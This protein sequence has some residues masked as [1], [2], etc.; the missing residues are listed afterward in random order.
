MSFQELKERALAEWDAFSACGRPRVL[1]GAGTCGRAAGAEDIIQAV[2]SHLAGRGLNADVRQV[3]CLGLCYAEPLVELSGPAMPR[4]LYGGLEPDRVPALLDDFFGRGELREDC[5]LAVMDGAAAGGIPAFHELPMLRGQVRI[6]LR[7]CGL[8]DPDSILHYVARGGYAG[9]ARALQMAPEQ[10]IEEV[11][12]SGLRGRGGVGFPTGRKWES[13]RLAA[14]EPKYVVANAEEGEAG[15]FKDR[16]LIEGDPHL[17]LEGMLIAGY[18]VGASRGIIFVQA[19]YGLCA[20]RLRRAIDAAEKQGL[21]GRRILGSGFSF[22]LSVYN[23][24]GGYV[25]GE[26][27]ALLECLE[28]RRAIP[29]AKPPFPA[30]EGLEGQPTVINN[31]ETLAGVP[32]IL[33]HGAPSYRARGTEGS[34]GTK[35]FSLSG[36]LKRPGTVEFP[37]GVTLRQLIFEASGGMPEGRRFRAVLVGGPTG[38]YVPESYLDLPLDFDSLAPI[39]AMM[40]SGAI[41]VTDD[42]TCILDSVIHAARFL[43]DESCGKCAPCRLGTQQMVR[44][45]HRI[46]TGSGRPG[47]PDL[48]TELAATLKRSALCGLGQAAGNPVVGSLRHFRAEYQSHIEQALCPAGVCRLRAA[49]ST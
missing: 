8:V 49:R 5:A 39:D 2:N 45:L 41:V 46:T 42:R 18:A 6:V 28:G 32:A 30:Q 48:L 33:L 9:L 7:N 15:T 16:M 44:I 3:G 13:V 21:C 25:C 38:G 35:L 1:V 14:G 12:R 22:A 43:A 47:D 4:V 23:A 11:N 31:V 27:T 36:D 34:P 17:L 19:N 29:R 40:G 37:L 26:E 24:L 10:V 20:E